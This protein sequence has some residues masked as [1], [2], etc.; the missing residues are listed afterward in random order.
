MPPVQGNTRA[1]K[2]VGRG[3]GQGEGIED[4]RDSIWNVNEENI[5]KNWKKILM[6]TFAL[7]WKIPRYGPHV[8]IE[9]SSLF[10]QVSLAISGNRFICLWDYAVGFF[11]KQSFFFSSAICHYS[12][13]KISQVNS[14][15]CFSDAKQ[16]F[17]A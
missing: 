11:D 8:N 15:C 12:S 16:I 2:W 14:F 1:K 7:L 10:P 4:F 13:V 6:I 3:A 17:T 9:K 5:I